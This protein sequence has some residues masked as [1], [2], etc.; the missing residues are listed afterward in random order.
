[1]ARRRADLIIAVGGDGTLLQAVRRTYGSGIPLVGVNAGRLGFLTSVPPEEVDA[2]LARILE[3][4]YVVGS[5]TVLALEVRRAGKRILETW[6][7]NEMVVN[8]GHH[9]H[10]VCLDLLHGTRP[11]NSYLCDGLIVATATGSTA[12]SL[13][14]GGPI[15]SSASDTFVITPICAH[16]LTNRPLVVGSTEQFS[17]AV[18]AKSPS[19]H[20]QVD[21]FT[22]MALKSGDRVSFRKASRDVELVH[23][24]E[25]DFY[26]VLRQKLRWSGTAI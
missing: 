9:S 6:A 7:L 25:R 14:A 4:D 18:P 19:L 20:L 24:P 22:Y 16:A 11:L 1:M 21:G 23:L 17:V 3:G 12:Y 5:R 15:V 2:A 13:S 10:L 8:R 26:S